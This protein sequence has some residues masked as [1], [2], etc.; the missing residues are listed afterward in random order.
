MGVALVLS[1]CLLCLLRNTLLWPLGR[2]PFSGLFFSHAY[3][4]KHDMTCKGSISWCVCITAQHFWCNQ[5]AYVSFLLVQLVPCVYIQL[6]GL[7]IPVV[8]LSYRVQ[9]NA[10]YHTFSSWP[11]QI[12]ESL[13]ADPVFLIF[14]LLCVKFKPKL[15]RAVETSSI[16]M[17][18]RYWSTVALVLAEVVHFVLSILP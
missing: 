17:A 4:N 2:M 6:L 12:M 15:L 13:K 5:F 16:A 10:S 8:S 14:S 9:V 3:G 18:P 1:H 7:N 11:G